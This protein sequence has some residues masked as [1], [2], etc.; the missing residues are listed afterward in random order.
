MYIFSHIQNKN[1]TFPESFS[2]F[3]KKKLNRLLQNKNKLTLSN[4]VTK[5]RTFMQIFLRPWPCAIF[6]IRASR[7]ISTFSNQPMHPMHSFS[8]WR[9]SSFRGKNKNTNSGSRKRKT[10]GRQLC[11]L[12]AN[13]IVYGSNV[14]ADVSRL[15]YNIKCILIVFFLLSAVTVS[16]E[17]W[18]W[19]LLCRKLVS[20][21]SKER[22]RKWLCF[23]VVV[24]NCYWRWS[25]SSRIYKYQV[26][27]IL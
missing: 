8:F 27:D 4:D 6:E 5:R 24:S 1:Q 20:V 3:T 14:Y 11:L 26:I 21:V 19:T 9:P 16:T 10:G 15:F 7:H 18:F 23:E 17:A 13:G 12:L 25:C 2:T 22:S